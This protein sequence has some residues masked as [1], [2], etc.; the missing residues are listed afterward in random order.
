MEAIY[1]L[2]SSGS[3]ELKVR[4]GKSEVFCLEPTEY[5]I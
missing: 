5:F 1:K 2:S 3:I 4:L